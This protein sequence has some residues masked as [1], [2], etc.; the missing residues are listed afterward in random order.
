[1]AETLYYFREF[2][3]FGSRA[4]RPVTGSYPQVIHDLFINGEFGSLK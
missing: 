1:M 2:W 3:E 4:G